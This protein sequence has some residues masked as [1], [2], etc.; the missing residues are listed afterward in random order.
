MPADLAEAIAARL[1]ADGGLAAA[2]AGGGGVWA[3][4][5]PNVD[6]LPYVVIVEPSDEEADYETVGDDGKIPYDDE[7]EVQVSCFAAASKSA[8][9]AI[10]TLVQQC[11]D[12]A[13]LT[14]D[15]G[16]LLELRRV[17]RHTE[18]DPDPGP[19]NVDVWM[20]VLRFRAIV[21]RTL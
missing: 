21:A 17:G 2:L 4:Q 13:P 14:F 19:G 12:D 11:L 16:D 10:G 6:L 15:D 9:K 5:A 3:G 8:A 20:H 18:L 7:S 1:K